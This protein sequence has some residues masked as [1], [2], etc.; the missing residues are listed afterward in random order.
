MRTTILP[1][2][3]RAVFSGIVA[4]AM[5]PLA[6]GDTM[7]PAAVA[8]DLL[9]APTRVVF[10]GTT[11]TASVTLRNTGTRQA[12]YRI[13]LEHYEMTEDGRTALV[14]APV[15]GAAPVDEMV[16][17]SPRQVLLEPGMYQTV[18]LLVRKP[19]DLAPGEYRSHVTFRAVPETLEP[20]ES[21]AAATTW[22]VRLEPVYGVAIPVIVR[23]GETDARIRIGE[24]RVV[25]ASDAGP[26]ALR[27]VLE[28]EGTR[29]T[30]G[31]IEITGPGSRRGTTVVGR[32]RGVAVWLPNPSRSLLVPLDP[33]LLA[34]IDPRELVVTYVERGSNEATQAIVSR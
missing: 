17:F 16:R 12:L 8:G 22:S 21:A 2:S 15:A 23:H 6:V 4:L 13:S 1:T 26:P 10:E 3:R 31:D 30:Y 19:A 18:R 28:R 25:P 24:A 29:S 32:A 20:A 5:S 34:T 27:V 9:V 33:K 7:A 11:R 14:E